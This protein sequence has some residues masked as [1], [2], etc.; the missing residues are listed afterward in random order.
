MGKDRD[1]AL[2]IHEAVVAEA[3]AKADLEEALDTELSDWK[4]GE[5][6]RSWRGSSPAGPDAARSDAGLTGSQ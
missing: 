1:A 6:S 3:C 4:I 2:G 5:A